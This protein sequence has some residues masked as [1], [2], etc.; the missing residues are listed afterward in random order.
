MLLYY[1]PRVHGA[2][3]LVVRLDAIGDFVIWLDAARALVR[4]Y[5]LQGNSVVLLGNKAWANWAREMKVA[6][7]VWE[8]DVS[9]FCNYLPYRWQWL[10]RIRK[11]G[12]KIAIQPAYSRLFLTEDS[13]V[14]ASGAVERI[15]STGE[16]TK[17]WLWF[18]SWSNS[19]YT[20]L[21]PA[22]PIPLMELKRNAEFS[23][24]LGFTDFK[25]R[26][27]IIQQAPS[28]QT[29]V[30]PQQP[31]A[32]LV[33]AA[34]WVG[35]EWPIDNFIKIGLQLIEVGLNIV[36]VGVS[37]DRERVSGLID[38]LPG[39]TVNLVGKTTLGELA[40]VLRHAT[41]VLTNETSAVHIG[42]AVGTSVVCILGGGHFGRFA[43]YEI[44]VTDESP[45]LPIIVAE[46]MPCYGCNW[47]CKYPRKNGEAVKCIQDIS[48]EK[49]WGAVEMALTKRREMIKGENERG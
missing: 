32:V 1:P 48:V 43:P 35:R 5:H 30:L 3:V 41:V 12:F 17:V 14:R 16:Q 19:W 33:P 34:S 44:E 23:R 27:P 6:D 11:A 13:L 8:I 40:E 29:N 36:V 28:E 7:E 49:V 42:A 2:R 10:R 4:H 15:G 39:E 25:A 38:G 46:P 45:T 37:A 31:Y 20:R 24:G 26:L 22:T 21:I 9:Q 47:N 18:K